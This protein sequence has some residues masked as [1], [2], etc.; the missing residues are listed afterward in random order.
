MKPQRPT[1][2]LDSG[3]ERRRQLGLPPRSRRTNRKTNRAQ[4]NAVV[5]CSALLLLVAVA[6][7]I[8]QI[9]R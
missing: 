6:S 4:E 5:I 8:W 1:Y 2:I 7:I 9:M 3:E